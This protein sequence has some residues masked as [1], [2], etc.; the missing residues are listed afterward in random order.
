MTRRPAPSS[1]SS[2]L[3]LQP[4]TVITNGLGP[5]ERLRSDAGKT[6]ICLG[7]TYKAHY[8]GFFGL[9][10]EQATRSL[11]A[12]T[13]FISA[14]SMWEKR[15]LSPEE[16]VGKIKQALLPSPIR[17]CFSSIARNSASPRCIAWA[18][19]RNSTRS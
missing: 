19:S 4:L 8:H 2:W 14:Q 5:L 13:V 1:R 10:C 7:G 17:G 15:G 3:P 12:N 9:V 16:E 18:V 11:R 6:V